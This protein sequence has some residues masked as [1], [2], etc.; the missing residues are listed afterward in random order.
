[1]QPA[2]EVRHTPVL[3]PEALDSL[4]IR[5]GGAYIDCTVGE[6]GHALAVLDEPA[7]DTRLLGIDLDRD[8]LETARWRLE[9]HGGRAVLAEGSFGDLREL[10]T[11]NGFVPADGVLLD[12]GVSSLQLETA[13]RGFSFSRSGRLDMRFGASQQ[14]TA[15]DLVNGETEQR[16]ATLIY[17]Y[18]EERKSRRVARAIVAARPIETTIE[19]AEVVSSAVGRGRRTGVHPATRTFQAIRIA[20]NEELQNLE[21]G[22]AQAVEVLGPKGR[23]VVISYHSLEDRIVKDFMR[24]QERACICPP[25]APACVCG[26]VATVRLLT[27][28]IVRPSDEEIETNR[29]SRSARM[30]VAERL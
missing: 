4:D 28:R 21:C 27:R 23:L 12:L 6:G 14:T 18:G 3:L 29:R 22:L 7:K 24:T 10:A 9:G 16:L 26:H 2:R 25:D 13:Q 30:R 8:A 15:H 19:L 17:K 11:S 1:V 20:V 5:S